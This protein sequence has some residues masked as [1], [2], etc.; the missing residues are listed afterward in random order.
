MSSPVGEAQSPNSLAEAAE[1]FVTEFELIEQADLLKSA[2]DRPDD[3][4]ISIDVSMGHLRALA[5]ALKAAKGE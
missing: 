4:I 5:A 2:R 1:P 3:E